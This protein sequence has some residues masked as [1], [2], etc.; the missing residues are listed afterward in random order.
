MMETEL[1]EGWICNKDCKV[2][3]FFYSSPDS[4]SLEQ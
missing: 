4:L 2:F 1:G 3:R